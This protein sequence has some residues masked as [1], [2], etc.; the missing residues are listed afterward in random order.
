MPKA[1][2]LRILRRTAIFGLIS[3]ALILN[4]FAISFASKRVTDENI[5][6]DKKDGV[7]QVTVVIA[8]GASDRAGMLVGDI[9]VSINGQTFKTAGQ[10]DQI[11][12]AAKPNSTM[13]YAI[14]RDGK[15]LTLEVRAAQQEIRIHQIAALLMLVLV[16]LFVILLEYQKNKTRGTSYFIFA[17]LSL[18]TFFSL[19]TN[20]VQTGLGTGHIF[21]LL[22]ASS[23]A[24]LPLLRMPWLIFHAL[25][26]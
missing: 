21:I 2:V 26:S 1:T 25:Q 9:I 8:G 15:P 17:Y 24:G 14:V 22:Q 6:A 7:V 11:L 20:M 19:S 13:L 18:A 4:S 5:F 3:Y 12:R 23:L 16:A 10:A